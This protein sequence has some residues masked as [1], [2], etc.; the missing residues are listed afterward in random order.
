MLRESTNTH[1]EKREIEMNK[2]TERKQ[3]RE[4]E[5]VYTKT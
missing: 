2:E 3:N 1:K 4:T 5:N